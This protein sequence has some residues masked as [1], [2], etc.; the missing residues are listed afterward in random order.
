MSIAMAFDASHPVPPV[1][2]PTPTVWCERVRG[3]TESAL[4][5]ESAVSLACHVN[6]AFAEAE[7]WCGLVSA[8]ARR[9]FHLCFE[10]NRLVLV[11]ERTGMSLCTCASLGYSFASLT[12]RLG[13]PAVM[14]ET[15]RLVA[16]PA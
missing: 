7:S 14:A 11:N 4:D 9:G 10:D 12:A 5:F 16:R 13:K 6:G 1:N 8:L 2:E 3:T 15:G